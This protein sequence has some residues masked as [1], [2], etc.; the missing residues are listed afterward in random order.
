[1][2]CSFIMTFQ[3]FNPHV[4][5]VYVISLTILTPGPKPITRDISNPQSKTRINGNVSLTLIFKFLTCFYKI[6]TKTK[7]CYSKINFENEQA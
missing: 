1:M 7:I 4:T 6:E 2:F 5:E 3:S